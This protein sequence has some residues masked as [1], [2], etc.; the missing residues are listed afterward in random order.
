MQSNRSNKAELLSL[1]SEYEIIFNGT[2]INNLL[3]RITIK[4][5]HEFDP[6]TS[7]IGK[8]DI[9]ISHAQENVCCG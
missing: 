6:R 3:F 4:Y 7:C 1:M 8:C 9:I 2:G 5:D